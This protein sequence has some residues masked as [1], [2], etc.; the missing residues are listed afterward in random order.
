MNGISLGL[1]SR[2]DDIDRLITALHQL[3]TEGPAWT[4][5]EDYRPVPDPRP[6][7]DWAPAGLAGGSACLPD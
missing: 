5:T 6:M 2:S 4:Y 1:G 3:H 7:P